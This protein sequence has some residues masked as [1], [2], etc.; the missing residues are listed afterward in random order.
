MSKI[1]NIVDTLENRISKVLHKQ[2]VL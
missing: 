1:E 2:E